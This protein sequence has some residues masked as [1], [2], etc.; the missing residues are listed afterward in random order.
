MPLLAYGW[1]LDLRFQNAPTSV[2]LE[3]SE[4]FTVIVGGIAGTG[5]QWMHYEQNTDTLIYVGTKYMY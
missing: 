5:G 2:Y 1:D 3:P 4:E